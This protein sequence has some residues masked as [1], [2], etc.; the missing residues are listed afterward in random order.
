[1]GSL[2]P[3]RVVVDHSRPA[4]SERMTSPGTE[5]IHQLPDLA[6][7]SPIPLLV[8]QWGDVLLWICSLLI[9]HVRASGLGE[10]PIGRART[11]RCVRRRA[12][13][14]RAVS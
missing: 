8:N 3:A 14:G 7:L 9:V 1:M 10:R 11:R 2:A 6:S 5:G 12:G 13:V 4:I